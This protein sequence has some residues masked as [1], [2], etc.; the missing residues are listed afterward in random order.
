[1]KLIVGFYYYFWVNCISFCACFVFLFVLFLFIFGVKNY[2][3]FMFIFFHI[4]FFSSKIFNFTDVLFYY[5][6][7]N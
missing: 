4:V 5:V 6:L 3:C 1:M 7:A 2:D